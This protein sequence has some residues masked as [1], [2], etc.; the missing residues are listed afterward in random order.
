M[1]DEIERIFGILN[2]EFF[3]RKLRS[4][5]IV[6]QPKKKVS[7][8]W[9]QETESIVLGADFLYLDN[10]E[11]VGCMLHE[12]IHILNYQMGI[13]DVTKNQ[14]HNKIFL[15]YALQ[16]GF[17]VIKHKTQGWSITSTVLPRNVIERVFVKKPNKDAIVKRNK[18]FESI[19]V[20]KSKFKKIR[21]EIKSRIENEKPTKTFFLKY[22][23][24]CQPPHNSIRSGRRPDGPNALNIQCLNC[25]S[26]F[27]CVTELE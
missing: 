15:K 2:V 17:I 10:S 7:L 26:S 8:R 22:E 5:P 27:E 25:K 1:I 13:V 3:D 21:S 14:Y 19:K 11:I 9:I 6:V 4:V 24:N 16:V 23:C 20:E 18:I 12:M